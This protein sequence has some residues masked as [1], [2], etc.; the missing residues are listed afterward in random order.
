MSWTVK[1][2]PK[3][4]EKFLKKLDSQDETL[5]KRIRNLELQKIPYVVI[6][7]EKEEKENKVSLRKRKEGDL[8][9][10]SIDELIN[11]LKDEI[12]TET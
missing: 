12:K 5:N 6:I 10:L 2:Y 7:G 4:T 1:Y 3:E 9:Q 8:G 11:K